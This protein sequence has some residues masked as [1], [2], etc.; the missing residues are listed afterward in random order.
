[1]K[2]LDLRKTFKHLYQPS[3]HKVEVVDVPEL[4]F[5]M[6]D[7]R[8]EKGRSPGDSPAFL[9]AV[10]ALFGASYTLKFQSKLRKQDAIDYPVMALEALWW[11]ETGQFELSKPDN[12][13][14]RAMMMQPE[15]ITK[16]RFAEALEQLHKK[17]PSPGLDRLR[18]ERFR[19]GLCIQTMHIGPYS[20]EPA[21]VERLRA[22]AAENGYSFANQ[23]HEIYLS[24]PRRS[25]PAKM[26]TV[27]R[28]GVRRA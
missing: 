12:W 24:D 9:E 8:I 20:E 25:A 18:L 28:H 22:F 17:K 1:M 4:S 2:K 6:V 7:G 13:S 26:K 11:V 19:E 5:L 27:L 21:T 3:A 10:Q 14:W 15:H 16:E 23:H